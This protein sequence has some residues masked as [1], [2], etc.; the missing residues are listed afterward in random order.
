MYNVLKYPSASDKKSKFAEKE[1]LIYRRCA[2]K[3]EK[4]QVHYNKIDLCNP[5]DSGTH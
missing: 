4:N 2:C 3:E 5:E 1:F